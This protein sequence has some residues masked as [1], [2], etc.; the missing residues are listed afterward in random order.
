[1]TC[2]KY[3]DKVFLDPSLK[4]GHLANFHPD[5]HTSN[6]SNDISNTSVIEVANKSINSNNSNTPKIEIL[7]PV[8][9]NLKDGNGSKMASF[10]CPKCPKTYNIGKSLRKH[11]RKNHNKLSICFCHHCP[12]VSYGS[13]LY[14][15]G[16]QN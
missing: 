5:I 1:M 6:T 2:C 7:S 8:T 4:N 16:K 9:N 12:K 3:C 15:V 14:R 13:L 10:K 11:C